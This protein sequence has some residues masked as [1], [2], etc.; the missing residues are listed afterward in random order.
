MEHFHVTA[1]EKRRRQDLARTRDRL[2]IAA[3]VFAAFFA[4]VTVRVAWVTVLRPVEARLAKQSVPAVAAG[5]LRPITET[6]LPG[7]RAMIVDRTGQPLAMSQPTRSVFAD[8][9]AIVDPLDTAKKL[10]TELPRLDVERTVKRLS[11][12]TKRFVYLER[13]ITPDEE[14]RIN[15]LGIPSVDFK[16]TQQ[17]HYHQG[18]G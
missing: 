16:Q 6:M 1:A 15:N 9:S 7:Q 5:P 2:V 4:V 18:V 14:A 12:L 17:R 8:P 11:D 3:G 10:K 13:Q